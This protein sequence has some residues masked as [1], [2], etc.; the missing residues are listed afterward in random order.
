MEVVVHRNGVEVVRRAGRRALVLDGEHDV[1]E[2][3]AANDHLLVLVQQHGSSR[4]VRHAE[5]VDL[6]VVSRYHAV[7]TA[8][9]LE[10]HGGVEV[11]LLNRENGALRAQMGND[12]GGERTENGGLETGLLLETVL[13]EGEEELLRGQLQ[14]LHFTAKHGIIE[15]V[16]VHGEEVLVPVARQVVHLEVDSL[17]RLRHGRHRLV[18]L[19]QKLGSGVQARG[20]RHEGE[21]VGRR[22][23]G[24]ERHRGVALVQD[25]GRRNRVCHH[26]AENAAE[27]DRQLH[28]AVLQLHGACVLRDG[29]V[30]LLDGLQVAVQLGELRGVLH[31]VALNRLLRLHHA[32]RV[33]LALG[34]LVRVAGLG[35]GE[36][37]LV[38]DEASEVEEGLGH[39]RIVLQLG[40]EFARVDETRLRA[41][42]RH[43]VD[44]APLEGSRGAVV[45]VEV[46][47]KEEITDHVRALDHVGQ[48]VIHHQLVVQK[49]LHLDENA[50][51]LFLVVHIAKQSQVVLRA[52][53]GR[54]LPLLYPALESDVALYGPLQRY[55]LPVLD[56]VRLHLNLRAH[57]RLRCKC[58]VVGLI[59]SSVVIV[60]RQGLREG[61]DE[62]ADGEL[63]SLAKDLVDHLLLLR[64]GE[65][66]RKAIATARIQLTVQ[67]NENQVPVVRDG[68]LRFLA[69]EVEEALQLLGDL[70]RIDH[71]HAREIDVDVA[72]NIGHQIVQVDLDCR[73]HF[74][75]VVVD[76]VFHMTSGVF[77]D[78]VVLDLQEALNLDIVQLLQ[79]PLFNGRVL[80]VELVEPDEQQ[81]HIHF[82]RD[83]VDWGKGV[84]A[85]FRG[86]LDVT[87]RRFRVQC[88]LE[89]SHGLSP[90]YTGMLTG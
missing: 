81:I 23:E 34:A 78:S 88:H 47:E 76:P 87:C 73:T 20:G 24:R 83:S 21:V 65:F 41:N 28:L 56:A 14:S 57:L 74:D 49:L 3:V 38:G 68:N 22:G 16:V 82:E 5:N 19:A 2:R 46:L 8:Q 1:V 43:L 44:L 69:D 70:I 61:E 66:R 39:G 13:L 89:W 60:V 84:C 12:G 9:Q 67:Q 32:R 31:R 48:L 53:C 17:L 45:E 59:C 29:A 54:S 63:A 11:G 77:L 80:A 10:E 35:A 52:L 15:E 79:N 62:L 90:Q 7:R 42:V 85:R 30:L 37:D 64:V 26:I 86:D 18:H 51:H 50:L 55:C 71:A 75:D 36:L 72:C 25:H 40:G 33:T 27:T 6:D 58:I 4:R